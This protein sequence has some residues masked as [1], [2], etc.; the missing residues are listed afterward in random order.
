MMANQEVSLSFRARALRVVLA[1]TL[2]VGLCPMPAYADQPHEGAAGEGESAAPTLDDVGG[3]LPGGGTLDNAVEDEA[4]VE[5][6][7]PFAAVPNGSAEAEDVPDGSD[8]DQPVLDEP[9]P[10]ESASNEPASDEPT[11]NESVS[12]GPADEPKA[13]GSTEDD[14]SKKA[15]DAD[16]ATRDEELGH[17]VDSLI[18]EFSS[19]AANADASEL[20]ALAHDALAKLVKY[21][22]GSEPLDESLQ[23]AY[24]ALVEHR[25]D[26]KGFALA[27]E[28]IMTKL[29][30]ECKMIESVEDGYVWNSVKLEGA[31]LHVDVAA[32]AVLYELHQQEVQETSCDG[33]CWKAYLLLDDAQMKADK[34]AQ[35]AKRHA[36]WKEEPREEAEQPEQP[37]GSDANSGFESVE[38][39]DP[40][41]PADDAPVVDDDSVEEEAV[42]EV[43]RPLNET[44][45]RLLDESE[46]A[47]TP[48]APSPAGY[49]WP[50]TVKGTNTGGYS[51][52]HKAIDI[53]VP[54]GSEVVASMA[55][56]VKYVQYWDGH[57]LTN[58]QSYGNMV[59]VYH[60]GN[61]TS[62]YY[63]HLSSISVR[64]GQRVEQGQKLGESGNTG[65][66]KGSNGGYHLHFEIR[67]NS[68]PSPT[69]YGR[70]DGPAVNPYNYV[71]NS[72]IGVEHKCD[73]TK[74]PYSYYQDV[75]HGA[76]C[77]VDGKFGYHSHEFVWKGVK[78]VCAQC[79]TEYVYHDGDGEYITSQATQIFIKDN[80]GSGSQ[81]T[82]PAGK[83]LRVSSI[84]LSSWGKW[85]G[86]V[87][88]NG[89]TGYANLADFKWNGNAGKHTF[90]NGKCSQCGVIQ[91][92]SSAGK[93]KAKNDV[94]L[95]QN[96]GS[97]AVRTV[98][99]GEL[100]T[101]T[102]VEPSTYNSYW[103][104]TA[105]GCV[106][107]M[108]Q[109]E[110]ASSG[111]VATGKVAKIGD[112]V[113]TIKNAY[114]TTLGLDV[115][116]ASKENGAPLQLYSVNNDVAQQF[117]F[118]RNKDDGTYLITNVNSG[119][120]LD[121]ANY[122][123]ANG[124]KV[125]QYDAHNGANQ[126]WYVEVN[127]DGSYSFRNK[128][129]N[130]YLDISGG[131]IAST[132]LIQ[133]YQG[134]STR[135][136]KFYV[137]PI[138]KTNSFS[139][140]GLTVT[141][142]SKNYSYTGKA[143]KPKPTVK[144]LVRGRGSLSAPASGVANG[145]Y[146]YTE[147]CSVEAGKT[148]SVEVG[149]IASRAGFAKGVSLLAYDFKQEKIIG[150]YT[151]SYSST[152]QTK[153][154]RIP[155]A[156]KLIVY[157]GMVGHTQGCASQLLDVKVYEV[158][159]E[160]KDYSV[161]YKNNAN[162]GA[163]SLTIAGKG[164]V[165][166]S[167]TIG[168]N[169]LR[170]MDT[171]SIAKISDQ[172]YTGKAVT[173][174]VKVTLKGKT[175][176]KGVDYTVSY[177]NNTRIGTATATIWARG[178]S[179]FTGS[180][181]IS[182]SIVADKKRLSGS[183]ALDTMTAVTKQGFASR[184]CDTVVVATTGGY[185]DALTASGLAGLKG[186]PVLLTDKGRLSSQTA[187][188][189]KRLGASRVYIAGGTSAVSK[190]V[191]SSIR[192]LSGVK[193]V[194]RLA[195]ST[196]VGTALKIYEERK[197]SWGNTA[198]VATS[199]GFQDALSISPYAYQNHA[200]IFLADSSTGKLDS[201]TASAIKKGGFKYVVIVGGK[202]AVSGQ[203]EKQL[204]GM[205]VKRLSGDTA[206]ETSA[207]VAAWCV[208]HGMKA[209]RM[210]VAT[211]SSYY[212]ALAGAALCG[213]Y[214]SALVL[215]DNGHNAA[216]K[217]FV[218][219]RKKSIYKLF[220]FGGTA[221]VSNATWK[222]LSAALK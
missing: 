185:W 77:P 195:G 155:S 4:V 5:G 57:T 132:A 37:A 112:G 99:K 100:V 92:A 30:I 192:K 202:A 154:I 121:A 18:A 102:Y 161:S 106:V 85:V 182:F 157:A 127:S 109:L 53:G 186:C 180:R 84:K 184:S 133:Q 67:I 10:D 73:F 44:E 12:D 28:R 222:E 153:T 209:N 95:V 91:A 200:P 105:D 94:G 175:L 216:A 176:K 33:D 208:S 98:K 97:S 49:I 125:I 190:G 114:N 51:A 178:G 24:G 38:P 205:T 126:R 123:I 120:A 50:L 34:N 135:A 160:N 143:I 2:V 181:K 71:N 170:S 6:E 80:P 69:G 46:G 201:R 191:E 140:G 145:N 108:D 111:T 212:D 167:K 203:V 152:K 26:A 198:I 210:G 64:Q 72:N 78:R 116:W 149:S 11:S 156:C 177:A 148:Y 187:S 3:S 47:L 48:R 22:E 62:T 90:V 54:K 219:K 194:K 76:Y 158:L 36:M 169:I 83:V 61:N 89:K 131:S 13:E 124:V 82:I 197:G 43:D 20:A 122:G 134:N 166:G 183:T 129:S 1:C 141:G 168:F 142:V 103:G 113:Y 130:L 117:K 75:S 93:Y 172:S 88:Y 179:T 206:Y 207:A 101:I 218:S 193:T 107:S 138:G 74:G 136:Q 39:L 56:T 15:E 7:T 213:R 32:D 144:K 14:A 147:V 137:M 217:S 96:V 139:A 118:T 215:V 17:A 23:T 221:A 189:I 87:S 199:G 150:Q 162:V 211:G 66:V 45:K 68:N 29:G 52:S 171:V 31:W 21:D 19:D 8:S 173:P 16:E 128:N 146:V 86:I 164:S 25:A 204:A 151:L 165:A 42:S 104:H 58:M 110:L 55:G 9:T 119:K 40:E 59:I 196:A 159:K 65:Y 188:E 174:P 27:Y 63:A 214:N 163:A 81:T 79:G 35:F 41:E 220:V 115:Q 70:N 60:P